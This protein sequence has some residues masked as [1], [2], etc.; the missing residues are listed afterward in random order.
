MWL[1]KHLTFPSRHISSIRMFLAL[2]GLMLTASSPSIAQQSSPILP[3]AT[4][5]PGAT[6]PVTID[7]IRVPGYTK[8]VRNV[9]QGVKEKVYTEY[10]ITSR[11]PREYEIDHLISLELGGSN[12]IRNLWPQSYLTQPWNAHVK[13]RL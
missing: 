1:P 4:F 12:S 6:L 5:T 2:I 11:A 10:G 3:N 8:K 7:D 13:D 9:P